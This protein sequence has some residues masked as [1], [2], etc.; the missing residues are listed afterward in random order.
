MS[1]INLKSD[2]STLTTISESVFSRLD[3]KIEWC[4]IDAI[5][6]ALLN[7]EDVVNINLG[8]GILTLVITDNSIKYKFKPSN[9]FEKNIINTIENGRNDLIL[10]IEN[11]L[12]SKLVDVY[13]TLL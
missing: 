6:S 11:S 13:K 12:T 10:N 9:R 5:E 4:I 2:L 3:E 7:N 8:I 1:T